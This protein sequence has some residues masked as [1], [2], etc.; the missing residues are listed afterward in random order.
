MTKSCWALAA[1]VVAFPATAAAHVLD[2]YLQVAQVA[3]APDGVRVELRLVPGVQVAD[4]VLALIDANGDGEVTAAEQQAYARDVRQYVTLAVDDQP[5]AM[6]LKDT[7]FPSRQEM[8][9]GVGVIRLQLAAKASLVTAG[10]HRVALRNDYRPD[11]GVYLANALV[12][13]SDTMT[14]VRQTRDPM[15]RGLQIDVDVRPAAATSPPR[16]PLA[17]VVGL[18]ATIAVVAARGRFVASRKLALR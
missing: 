2:Q 15:Q 17:L 8:K 12:P 7:Q 3:L 10:R 9:D 11:I 4:R 1:W 5:L 16:W 13:K 14:V 18:L 6:E